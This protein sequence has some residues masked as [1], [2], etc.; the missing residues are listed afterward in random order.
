MK[1]L[2]PVYT[3]SNITAMEKVYSK[4][5]I[6]EALMNVSFLGEKQAFPRWGTGVSFIGNGRKL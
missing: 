2:I 5:L 1:Y 4:D 3:L 6:P